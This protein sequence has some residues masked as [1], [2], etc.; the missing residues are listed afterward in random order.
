M[1]KRPLCLIVRDGWGN[2]PPSDANAISKAATPRTD[3]FSAKYPVT[4]IK[5]HGEY[6]GLEPGNQGNSEVGHLN[7]GAGRVV[8]QSMTRI[9]K[10]IRDGDFFKNPVFLDALSHCRQNGS[11]LHL[12][13]LIQD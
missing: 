4:L 7:L 11:T 6:V 13:G 9:N 8:Y 2:A 3:E 12:F 1:P 10:S 5:A